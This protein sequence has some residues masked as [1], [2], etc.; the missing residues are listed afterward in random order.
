VDGRSLAT[1]SRVRHFFRSVLLWTVLL[2]SN[3]EMQELP[4]VGLINSTMPHIARASHRSYGLARASAGHPGSGFYGERLDARLD[5][6]RHE[7]RV[8]QDAAEG[9][10]LGLSGSS[11]VVINGRLARGAQWAAALVS[12]IEDKLV[13]RGAEAM[14]PLKKTRP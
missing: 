4:N 9:P 6:G 2:P 12:V 3:G 5:S 10:R 14:T 8:Q 11:E 7:S 13:R 1:P